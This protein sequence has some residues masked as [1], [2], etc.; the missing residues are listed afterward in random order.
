[1]K[2]IKNKKENKG[3]IRLMNKTRIYLL[4]LLIPSLFLSYYPIISLGSSD[5]MNYELSLPLVLLTLFTIV[6]F[7]SIYQFIPTITKSKTRY[8][9]LATLLFPLYSSLSI[10]W[11]PNSSRAILTSGIIWCLYFSVVSIIDLLSQKTPNVQEKK[12]LCHK[13]FIISSVIICIICWLQCLLDVLGI[14]RDITLLCLGCTYKSFG[15]PHPSGFAIEPQF[16]GNL[17]L[18]PTIYILYI[19]N[20]TEQN[21]KK[22]NILLLLFSTTLF[23]TFSRGAIFAFVISATVLYLALFIKKISTKKSIISSLGI[24]IVSFFLCLFSQGILS[25]ISPT[26]DTFLSGI[27]KSINQL[28]LGTIDI[29]EKTNSSVPTSFQENTEDQENISVFDGYVE[30]STDVRLNLNASALSA[31]LDSLT[32]F[33]FGYG[34]GSAGTILANKGLTTQPKEIVQNEYLSLLLEVGI[35]GL[36]F[37]VYIIVVLFITIKKSLKDFPLERFSIESLLLAF[38]FTLLFFSGLPN[39]LHL[40]LFPIFILFLFPKHESIID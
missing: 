18:A 27:T 31:S 7:P 20:K 23:L 4:Y 30:E 22:Q 28:S 24:T 2:R 21:V 34:L 29:R 13:I 26:N 10:L 32:S 14:D 17:L 19:C 9:F 40:Y 16:M 8:F 5:A 25:A 36:L 37:F 11:S 15:F 12:K 33:L 1:M 39:A 38:L 6:S 3:I 35:I